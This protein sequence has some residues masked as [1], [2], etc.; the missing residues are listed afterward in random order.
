M[1]ALEKE[2]RVGPDK[3]VCPVVI[4]AGINWMTMGLRHW[5]EHNIDLYS[6]A[7]ALEQEI[8]KDLIM[9]G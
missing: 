1:F 6:H 8:K 5:N 7:G 3:L 2:L 9:G 4:N